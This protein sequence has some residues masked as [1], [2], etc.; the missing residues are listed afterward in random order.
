MQSCA[1]GQGG[2]RQT[3]IFKKRNFLLAEAGKMSYVWYCEDH[4]HSATL[5]TVDKVTT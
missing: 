3:A 5:Q 4:G 2:M 1:G